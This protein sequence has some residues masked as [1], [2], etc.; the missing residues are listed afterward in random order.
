HQK[1][2][3][4]REVPGHRHDG[5]SAT[6]GTSSA[7]V[8]A[9]PSTTTNFDGVGNGFTGPSGTFTVNSAPPDTNGATGP[10]H[11][12]QIVNSDF[13]IFNKAG[14]V[15]FGPVPINTLWSGFGGLCQTD[16]DGDPT[17]VYDRMADRFVISQFAVTGANGGSAPFLQCV[18]VAQTADPT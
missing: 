3:P 4:H 2:K 18:A 1:Q 7:S 14:T 5:N 15:V 11:Y 10:N 9:I 16:N 6:S 17:V 8:A 12:I 13:A